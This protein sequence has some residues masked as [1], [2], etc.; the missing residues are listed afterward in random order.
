MKQIGASNK[1]TKILILVSAGLFIWPLFFLVLPNLSTHNTSDFFT[2]LLFERYFVNTVLLMLGTGIITC[3]VGVTAA[4]LVTVYDFAGKKIIEIV[5]MLPLALPTYI[6]ALTYSKLLEFSGPIQTFLRNTFGWNKGDYWFLSIQSISGAIFITSIAFYPYVYA[7]A[8]VSFASIGGAI[9]VSRG[10][11]LSTTQIFFKLAIQSA[12]PA[13]VAGL[14][15]VLMETLADFGAVDQLAVETFTV[16]IYRI[17]YSA[18]DYIG[19]AKISSII[20]AFSAALIMLARSSQGKKSY[21]YNYKPHQSIAASKRQ[22]LA[23]NIFCW[24]VAFLGYILPLIILICWSQNLATYSNKLAI[25]FSNTIYISVIGA[26]AAILVALVFAYLAKK[27]RGKIISL[28]LRSC[29]MG[30]AIPG[31]VIAISLVAGL[32]KIDYI[33]NTIM[34]K[35]KITSQNLALNSTQLALIYAYIFRFMAVSMGSIEAGLSKVTPQIDWLAR[36]YT[37]NRLVG[38]FAIKTPMMT[39][40][41]FIG[42]LLV[43]IEII[44]E[45][46]ITLIIRPFNFETLATYTHILIEDERYF[47]ASLPALTVS[48]ICII[49]IATII[50]KSFKSNSY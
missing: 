42:F 2:H 20:L 8:R 35:T 41:I 33:F 6:S 9:T 38:L 11:G 22:T 21:A 32:C 43:F 14:S 46:P 19:A 3:I 4:W 37:R 29:T 13:I 40:S 7:L 28:I 34:T 47:E 17:W 15:I 1:G 10:L 24:S 48:S 27:Q 31:S 16:G 30:Y 25:L 49:P 18:Q 50:N 45:L 23:I 5:L 26:C 12:K 39:K 44:K 36:I